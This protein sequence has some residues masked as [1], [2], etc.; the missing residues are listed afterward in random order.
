MRCGSSSRCIASLVVVAACGAAPP[1]RPDPPRGPAL[2]TAS[3]VL[4]GAIGPTGQGTTNQAPPLLSARVCVDCPDCP[5]STKL[6]LRY[7][8]KAGVPTSRS[9]PKRVCGDGGYELVAQR[10]DGDPASTEIE[11]SDGSDSITAVF[12][13]DAFTPRA[14]SAADP[15]ALSLCHG[16]TSSFAWSPADDLADASITGSVEFIRPFKCTEGCVGGF[17]SFDADL[18]TTP[19]GLSFV[20]PN[21]TVNEPMVSGA[22]T[23]VLRG[24]DTPLPATSCEGGA[25][26]SYIPFRVAQHGATVAASCP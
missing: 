18:A 12:P 20:V 8:G 5:P 6:E 3:I 15:A 19:A 23:A 17:V 24:D 26:C 7:R 14:L 25:A 11:V 10:N 13:A 2:P 9:D 1:D 16:K 21:V 4:R 22:I